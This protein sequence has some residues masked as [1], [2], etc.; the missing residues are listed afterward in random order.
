MPLRRLI[1]S[2]LAAMSLL[3]LLAVESRAL[4]A[5]EDFHRG[6]AAYLAG[7]HARA[8]RVLFPLAVTGNPEAQ[9]V[10]ARMYERGEFFDQDLC[11]S[12]VWFDKAARAGD[13]AAMS[14]LALAYMAGRGV[15][16]DAVRAQLWATTAAARGNETAKT[17]LQILQEQLLTDAQFAEAE[18]LQLSFRPEDQAPVD[19]F[20]V[21]SQWAEGDGNAAWLSKL[22]LSACQQPNQQNE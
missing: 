2:G 22:G 7:A 15:H 11:L 12:L 9:L 4:S 10:I 13:P 8:A 18:R 21:P 6:V 20:P 5:E 14:Y 16:Y 3:A 1:R 19:L 17:L